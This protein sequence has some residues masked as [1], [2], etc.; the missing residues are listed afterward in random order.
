MSAYCIVLCLCVCVGLYAG[1]DLNFLAFFFAYFSHAAFVLFF[2]VLTKNFELFVITARKVAAL[3]IKFKYM[4]K[5]KRLNTNPSMYVYQS[6]Q[7]QRYL[8]HSTAFNSRNYYPLLLEFI[9]CI[10]FKLFSFFY[11][12]RNKKKSIP[13]LKTFFLFLLIINEKGLQTK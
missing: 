7:H 11:L 4:K 6:I 12:K 3:C 1:C 10:F 9:I 2:I 13:K 8:F 5:K